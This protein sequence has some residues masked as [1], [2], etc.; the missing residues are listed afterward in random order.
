M[1]AKYFSRLTL[2]LTA[3]VPMTGLG[4][5]AAQVSEIRYDLSFDAQTAQSRMV[6]VGMTF[7]APDTRP[8]LLSLPAWTPG[9]YQIGNFARDVHGFAA[10]QEGAPI[11]W[12]KTDPDTWRVR[13]T[14]AGQVRVEFDFLA[15]SLDNAMAWARPDFLMVNGTNVFL[16]PEGQGLEFPARVTVT[17]EP[18]WRV[19]TGMRQAGSGWSYRADSYHDLVDMPFFIGA[20][21]VDGITIGGRTWRIASWP[22]GRFVGEPRA[23]LHRQIRDMLP[24]M[25]GPWGEIPFDGYTTLL[26]FDEE[27]G[28]GSALEHQNSHVGIYHPNFIGTP[29]LAS[30]TAHEIIHA[31]NVKR[32]RPADLVP[33]RYDMPQPTPWLWVSEG[34]TDYYADL[35]LVRGGVVDSATFLALLS[36][37][38]AETDGVPPV[39]LEDAS[40]S[41]WI[42]PTDGTGYIYYPKGALAG[43][44]LDILIRDATDNAASLDRVMGDLYRSA[45][46]AGRGFTEADWWGAVRAAA[47]GRDFSDFAERYIDGREP[48]PW[49]DVLPR[50][51]LRLVSETFRE[52]R[53]GIS[54]STDQGMTLIMEVVPGSAAADAGVQPGDLLLQVGE[55]PVEDDSFGV[56]FRA[57]YADGAEGDPIGIVVQRGEQRLVL[58]AE[59]RFSEQTFRTMAPDPAAPERARRIRDGLF[60]GR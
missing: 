38:M 22:A 50:A 5:L 55:V 33:Y 21:D 30:I 48:F 37:K 9:A 53:I 43:F 23:L 18:E 36:E 42:E 13:P 60:R 58:T 17:T 31:W 41:I 14:A 12:D 3:G 28:G 26:I 40:L 4:H 59:L 24:A 10:S 39:A 29:L 2:L 52:P 46:K 19:A 56:R 45:W 8:V 16:Y 54:T 44:L 7:H 35:A 25:S 51:G 1:F 15:D 49:A 11:R 20:L 32:L 34:I 47:G 57:R 6:R 27:Y